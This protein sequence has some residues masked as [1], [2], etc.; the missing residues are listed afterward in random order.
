MFLLEVKKSKFYA[1]I[2]D[3]HSLVEVKKQLQFLAKA[4]KKARH[5]CYAYCFYDAQQQLITGMSDDR[6][7]KGS[8][9]KS[10]FNNLVQHHQVNKLIVVVRYFGGVKLGFGGLFRAYNQAAQLVFQTPKQTECQ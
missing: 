10:L 5:I 9:G 8:A 7:P 3:V 6:E 4:H 2:Y 1:Q